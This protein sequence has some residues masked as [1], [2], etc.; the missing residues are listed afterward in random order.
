MARN[1]RI[2]FH[3][4]NG[5]LHCH[6]HGTLDGSSAWELINFIQSKYENQGNIFIETKHLTEVLP[7]ASHILRN[8]LNGIMAPGKNLVFKGEK[9][10]EIAPSGCQVLIIADKRPNACSKDCRNC[11][12]K[13]Q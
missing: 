2:R 5:N 4:S 13:K 10:Y 9:G 3:R 12:C 8:N 1:F 11:G 6:P 7:F